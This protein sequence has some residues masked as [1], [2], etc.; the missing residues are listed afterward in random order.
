MS[1]ICAIYVRK[2]KI[3]DNSDSM[4]TQI[5]M[6][7]EYL[8]QQFPGCIIKIYDKDYGIT[9]HSIKK[10]KDFQ[11]MMDDV[12]SGSINIVAIQ[13][14]DRIARNTRDFCNIYHDMEKVNCEL[15]SVSQRIDT[16]TPYGKKFMYD[17]ASTAEL[18]WALN[19][20]RHKDTNRYA[21]LNRKCAL[22]PY[23]LPFGITAEIR[24]GK[25]VAVIDK[26]REHIVRDA[27]NY[28]KENKSKQKTTRYINSKYNLKLSHSFMTNLIKSDFYHG[29]YREVPDYCEAYMTPEEHEELRNINKQY[30]R[31]Y[32]SDK[33]YFLFTGL[34]ICPCCGLKMESQSQLNKSGSRY[35]YYRC[36]NTY[37][38]GK[39]SFK[40][41]VNEK[42]VETYLLENLEKE[43]SDFSTR[44]EEKRV[45][46]KEKTVDLSKLKEE[47]ERLNK[48]YIKG[49]IEED[50]YNKEY[51]R[52]QKEIS[53][54]KS[55]ITN[56]PKYN[57]E[58]F[59]EIFPTDWKEKYVK[60]SREIKR[61][62]WKEIISSI[63]INNEKTVERLIFK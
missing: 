41:N 19:S 10:R 13:R 1:K 9:G 21:R 25:R 57:I 42:V 56:K 44:L 16:S 3:N 39:C 36:Y 28:Y 61:N 59:K 12:R 29:Q 26:E 58:N 53:L 46:T 45:K 27:I 17:L 5:K 34:L 11:R 22:S 20:E 30:V 50:F 40:G 47:M 33:Q 55:E 23:A 6:C 31:H 4:E 2:S 48:L 54:G 14:Y 52:L 8:N 60:L 32:S 7:E 35:Y 37:R 24:D 18:E 38:T 62:L 15:V 43:M 49:R 63:E 51:E